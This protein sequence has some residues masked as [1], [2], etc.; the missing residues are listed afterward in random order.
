MHVIPCF[1]LS[2]QGEISRFD[3]EIQRMLDAK[4][5][6]LCGV[7]IHT[8]MAAIQHLI[9][10]KH[11]FNFENSAMDSLVRQFAYYEYFVA[12]LLS[13]QESFW[14]LAY[15]TVCCWLPSLL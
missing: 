13:L 5:C 4:G 3:K 15:S 1:S 12:L 2:L 9:S 11:Q 10:L 7:Q 8:E 14:D 6:C